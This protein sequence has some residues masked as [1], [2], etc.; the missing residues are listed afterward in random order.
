MSP[1]YMKVVSET[2]GVAGE[3]GADQESVVPK[4]L[5]DAGSQPLCQLSWF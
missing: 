2:T 4:E 1:P 5:F 3:D